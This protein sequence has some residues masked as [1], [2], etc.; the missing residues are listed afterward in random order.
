MSEFLDTEKNS[1]VWTGVASTKPTRLVGH[2]LLRLSSQKNPL[3]RIMD[4]LVEA[5]GRNRKKSGCELKSPSLPPSHCV[6]GTSHCTSQASGKGMEGMHSITRS[7]Q[8]RGVHPPPAAER[9]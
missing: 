6:S 1:F 5:Q 9:G 3:A 7:C 4:G 2:L 8:S